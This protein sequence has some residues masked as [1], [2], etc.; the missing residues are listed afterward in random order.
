MNLIAKENVFTNLSLAKVFFSHAPLE[1]S[2][3]KRLTETC[4]L[5][6]QAIIAVQQEQ[7]ARR[8]RDF[9]DTLNAVLPVNSVK[10]CHQI[11]FNPCI[12]LKGI[13][14]DVLKNLSIISKK[15][16]FLPRSERK[17][18]ADNFWYPE[19][20]FSRT[21]V[22]YN[23]FKEDRKGAEHFLELKVYLKVKVEKF[24]SINAPFFSKKEK[25][26]LNSDFFDAI[27][28]N[29]H[30]NF[31]EIKLYYAFDKDQ[32]L[33]EIYEKEAIKLVKAG[34]L[35][36]A[37]RFHFLAS[38]DLNNA[39]C[40]GRL[41]ENA[42]K[43]WQKIL[44]F[45]DNIQ[46]S[47]KKAKTYK[48]I[49]EHMLDREYLEEAIEAA[50]RIY[51][52]RSLSSYQVI[53][54]M[55][56]EAIDI[57]I[58]YYI[59]R[60]EFKN[61]LIAILK[62]TLNNEKRKTCLEALLNN[63]NF[64]HW[65]DED[66]IYFE[67]NFPSNNLKLFTSH[68][69]KIY[70]ESKCSPD[71]PIN[72][73]DNFIY[74]YQPPFNENEHSNDFYYEYNNSVNHLAF[75]SANISQTE[76]QINATLDLLDNNQLVEALFLAAE[77]ENTAFPQI[78]T[79]IIKAIHVYLKFHEQEAI[80]NPYKDENNP[81][82]NL[83]AIIPNEE[84]L[85]LILERMFTEFINNKEIYKAIDCAIRQQDQKLM[86]LNLLQIFIRNGNSDEEAEQLVDITLELE[87][88]L[89]RRASLLD[90]LNLCY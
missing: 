14:I 30:L 19:P 84:L 51:C 17:L 33:K 57:I 44:L 10:I 85:A 78:I 47:L 74:N 36:I 63:T 86:R 54:K 49:F 5:W 45:A 71:T 90:F 18:L 88:I 65:K 31:K 24:K 58:R 15:I 16:L 53:D 82:A 3:L 75:A 69:K 32:M 8:S 27:F 2:D 79:D 66:I 40:I 83:L 46:D 7:E 26:L 50:S 37:E 64:T 43:N 87:D 4:K 38:D 9:I 39:L 20:F 89:D 80:K 62:L 68:Q 67:N 13:K 48:F 22:G 29:N 59:V 73:L 70:N 52:Q 35:D 42:L 60:K 72:Q 12:S 11:S 56:S 77:L 61:A 23:W 55:N 34:Q 76:K 21:L 41:L 28:Q 1:E 81:L 6:N 25:E